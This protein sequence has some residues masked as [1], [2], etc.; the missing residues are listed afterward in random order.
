MRFP[1]ETITFENAEGV[2]ISARLARPH[3]MHQI[4]AYAL[5]AH[6]F[7]CSKDLQAARTISHALNE[8]G[9][10]VLRFDFTGLGQSE[11]EFSETGFLNNLDDLARA[12]AYLAEHYE[13]PQLMVGHSL[14]GT[15][16]IY[17]SATRPEMQS[18]KAVVS[19]G[20]PYEP[21]HVRHL[22]SSSEEQ[23]IKQGEAEVN[24][25]GR[26]FKIKKTFLDQLDAVNPEEV[27]RNLN[28]ALLIMHAPFDKIVGI[29]EAAKIYMQAMH[30]KSFI[31][32]DG[33][34]H[35]L[36]DPA[37]S[38][39][40]GQMV[41]SWA[42]RYLE[43]REAAAVH[44]NSAVVTRTEGAYTT[45]ILAGDHELLADEP[46]FVGGDDLGPGPYEYLLSSLGACTGMTLR[47]Y[48]N[49]KKWPMTAVNVH[50]DHNKIHARDCEDCTDDQKQSNAKIDI[51]YKRLEIE[52]DLDETQ[53]AR[54]LEIASRCPVHR[55]LLG[56][57]KIETAPST[58]ALEASS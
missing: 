54:L 15:A 25:G 22:I 35:L 40:A 52:G 34:D 9:I 46:K 11:G 36:S 58:T 20:S 57:I 17:A 38:A 43:P 42:L 21:D 12:A 53:R 39:Y 16:G 33:A 27:I 44:S 19:I 45:R 10:A 7:T 8:A 4:R 51:I 1:Q 28:K 56:H 49:R 55:T 26:P 32:L 6:C 14:G 3:A 13:A 50:L 30:P 48:A 41:A 23:I 2:K 47:M 24:I 37:D 29:D 5:F 31:S 18:I